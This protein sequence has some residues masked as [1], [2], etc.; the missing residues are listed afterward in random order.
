MGGGDPI[1]NPVPVLDPVL[2]PDLVASPLR[3]IKEIYFVFSLYFG[4]EESSGS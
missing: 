3:L 1:P 4:V 2:V